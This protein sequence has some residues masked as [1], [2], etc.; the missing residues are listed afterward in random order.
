M[1]DLD[2]LFF[3]GGGVLLPLSLLFTSGSH[4]ASFKLG[5]NSGTGAVPIAIV[6]N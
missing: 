5:S 2:F 1:P 4:N 3:G 6:L